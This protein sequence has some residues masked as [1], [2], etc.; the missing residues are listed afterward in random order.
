MIYFHF[1][2][3]QETSANVRPHEPLRR[4]GWLMVWASFCPPICYISI[5]HFQPVD[6]LAQFRN[7]MQDG[8]NFPY[9]FSW[10]I[11]FG[12]HVTQN[13][14]FWLKPIKSEML[15]NLFFV[16]QKYWNTG[17]QSSDVWMEKWKRF[18]SADMLANTLSPSSSEVDEI[19]QRKTKQNSTEQ[20]KKM[21]YGI[22]EWV[23]S[24]LSGCWC[25]CGNAKG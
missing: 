16:S 14:K 11:F 6:L 10:T 5:N 13:S 12:T 15:R 7:K 23:K 18:M 20:E 3:T 9:S 4:I 19:L 1:S 22:L 17:M 24:Y 25:S 8:A 2:P 21:I